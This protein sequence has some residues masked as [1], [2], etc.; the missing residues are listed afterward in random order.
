CS[1]VVA[2]RRR[3]S[4]ASSTSAAEG[5]QLTWDAQ[6]FLLAES[7]QPLK[8]VSSPSVTCEAAIVKPLRQLCALS[9]DLCLSSRGS[10]TPRCPVS[11]IAGENGFTE[12]AKHRQGGM[13]H[14]GRSS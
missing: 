8:T 5:T 12:E 6:R 13:R 7:S 4:L 3:S 1:P 2:A 11:I 10:L 9:G 14:A